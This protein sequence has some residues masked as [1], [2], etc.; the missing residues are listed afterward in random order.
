MTAELRT[1]QCALKEPGRASWRRQSRD[2]SLKV[3]ESGHTVGLQQEVSTDS[4]VLGAGTLGH[5]ETRGQ[6]PALP[7]SSCVTLD[8]FPDVSEYQFPPL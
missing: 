1:A 5:D 3:D 2:W 7:C 6:I 4:E 8:K